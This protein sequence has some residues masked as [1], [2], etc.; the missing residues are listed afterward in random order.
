MSIRNSLC[1][2]RLSILVHERVESCNPRSFASEKTGQYI[3]R[4]A[5]NFFSLLSICLVAVSTESELASYG[6]PKLTVAYSSQHSSLTPER[7]VFVR[8]HVADYAT[9]E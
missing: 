4:I 7:I 6:R 2:R 3:T 8:G 5:Y 9:I 1:G